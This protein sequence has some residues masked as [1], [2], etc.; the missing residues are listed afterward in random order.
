MP[1]HVVFDR[2]SGEI[3]HTHVE[4]E[5]VQSAPE[6]ILALVDPAHE[7][8]QLDVMSVEESLSPGSGPVYVDQAARRLVSLEEG[9]TKGNGGALPVTYQ[10][11]RV[12]PPAQIV[13]EPAPGMP[14][15]ESG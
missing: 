3:V 1:T 9:K 5:D 7:H 4:S 10:P 12:W 14:S 11:G 13:Y 15:K 8:S 6:D 2:T